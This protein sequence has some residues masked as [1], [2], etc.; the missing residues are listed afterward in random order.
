M[1]RSFYRW[2]GNTQFK[3]AQALLTGEGGYEGLEGLRNAESFF[4]RAQYADGL[5]DLGD[6]YLK[7]R[8]LSEAERLFEEAND[9]DGLSAVSEAYLQRGDLLSASRVR[10]SAQQPITEEEYRGIGESLL[11]RG[12]LLTAAEAFGRGDDEEG[13]Y[14]ASEKLLDRGNLPAADLLMKRLGREVSR[15]RWEAVGEV[16]LDRGEVRGAE[17]AFKKAGTPLDSGRIQRMGRRYLKEGRLAAAFFAFDRAGDREGLEDVAEA[18]GSA[19]YFELYKTAMEK[20]GNKVD[21]EIC[22]EKAN[23]FLERGLFTQAEQAF[24]VAEDHEGLRRVADETFKRGD[25]RRALTLG[26]PSE[27]KALGTS[28]L[29]EGRLC[30]AGLTME[31]A[32]DQEGLIR[33]GE[34]HAE[35]GALSAAEKAFRNAGAPVEAGTYRDWG[36]RWHEKGYVLSAR[37]AK[38][39]LGETPDEEQVRNAAERYLESGR[40]AS[41]ERS[42]SLIEDR[43]GLA[44]V[45]DRYL[46]VGDLASATRLHKAAGRERSGTE[47]RRISDEMLGRGWLTSAEW[48]RSESGEPMEEEE[49]RTLGDRF[50][51]QGFVYGAEWAFSRINDTEGLLKVGQ[52]YLDE[53]DLHG[54]EGALRKADRPISASQYVALGDGFLENGYLGLARAAYDAAGDSESKLRLASA[55]V[56]KG[57]LSLAETIIQEAGKSLTA[58]D[59]CSYGNRYLEQKN[60]NAAAYAFRKAQDPDGLRSTGMAMLEVGRLK[61]AIEVFRAG[62]VRFSFFERLAYRFRRRMAGHPVRG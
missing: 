61:E 17:Q 47:Y 20:A 18:A 11:E 34:A 39:R 3:D 15:E 29:E 38:K 59:Y 57:E 51:D 33:L 32:S 50:L 52:A 14:R 13:V 25:V 49:Y 36:T 45:G 44:R 1:I 16:L 40:L 26:M 21:R 27:M 58:D 55:L 10:E 37:R 31:A 4:R 6:Q 42:L 24:K 7:L 53:A 30:P 41:A 22:L 9:S 19:G 43:A 28:F 54:A 62:D 56:D 23:D 35:K 60:L 12:Y 8:H 5:S 46:E 48:G 2:R